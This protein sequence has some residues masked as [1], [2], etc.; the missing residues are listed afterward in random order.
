MI[1]QFW[2]RHIEDEL[3]LIGS[4]VSDCLK[5]E[6]L[7]PTEINVRTKLQVLA[8]ANMREIGKRGLAMC[9]HALYAFAANS[10]AIVKD[11][12]RECENGVHY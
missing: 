10:P 3:Q 11:I 9:H 4:Q 12:T 7:A 6:N 8:T 1:S 5:E 2:S